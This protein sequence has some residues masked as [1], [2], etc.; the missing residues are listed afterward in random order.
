M[1]IKNAFYLSYFLLI[2]IINLIIISSSNEEFPFYSKQ[3]N[4]ILDYA[5]NHSNIIFCPM[6]AAIEDIFI[7]I[8]NEEIP[9]NDNEYYCDILCIK[10]KNIFARD[11]ICDDYLEYSVIKEKNDDEFY[12]VKFNNCNVLIE[13]ELNYKNSDISLVNFG[14]FL[15]ELKFDSIIFINNKGLKNGME[16]LFENS[17]KKFNYNRNDAIF[18]S[19][20]LDMNE[21]MDNIMNEIFDKFLDKINDKIIKTQG[22]VL[23]ESLYNLK[24]EYFS[25]FA[26][27]G[28]NEKNKS[29]TYIAYN[30]FNYDSF[31]HI[32]NKFFFSWINVTF[33]YALNH[34]IIFNEG[35]FV[36]NNIMFNE[37]ID[38]PNI[39]DSRTISDYYAAFNNLTE[40][41]DI[42][43]TIINDFEQ[44]LNQSK[45]SANN[46]ALKSNIL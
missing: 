46:N 16:V 5:C 1:L 43:K 23:Q 33:E 32:N 9:I 35:Y 12:Q 13:G 22:N 8:Q 6:K 36:I 15:S 34:N 17:T 2:L 19:E 44:K 40:N 31:I 41:Q 37:E 45:R 26:G 3:Q 29:V 27:K 21:Q 28:I 20:I 10:Y 7:S 39:Y 14:S 38:K 18:S 25:Y 24:N 30:D 11:M 4:E 42:L